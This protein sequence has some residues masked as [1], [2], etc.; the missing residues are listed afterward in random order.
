MPYEYRKLS[1]AQRKEI[2]EE[3]KIQG[4]PL[5]APPHPFREE[6]TFLITA[7]NYEHEP[8][9]QTP[10]RR[11]EFE[12]L[13][14]TS[15]QDV[16][17][18]IIAWVILPNHYHLL[19]TIEAFEIISDLLQYI[20]GSTSYRWNQEDSLTGERK[21]WY[22]FSDRMVRNETHLHRAVN[23]IHYNPV[24]HGLVDDVY[25]WQWSSLFLYE[26]EKG[27]EWLRENWKEYKPSSQFG[28]GWD[29]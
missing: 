15:F 22:R 19:V 24:K 9:L 13:L 7:A 3:R 2:L 8:A 10:E 17:A 28:K 26:D 6:G 5:H 4:Y 29:D 14:L 16:G 20:H 21:V 25:N 27:Q 1:P 12:T 11:T 18:K 23:Y